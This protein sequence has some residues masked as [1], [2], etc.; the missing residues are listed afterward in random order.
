MS[1]DGSAAGAFIHK[2]G[3]NCA[4]DLFDLS[5]GGGQWP[6]HDS[7]SKIALLKGNTQSNRRWPWHAD[8]QDVLDILAENLIPCAHSCW[9]T[10]SKRNYALAIS[11]RICSTWR[12]NCSGPWNCSTIIQNRAAARF[13]YF[14]SGGSSHNH[15][16]NLPPSSRRYWVPT[17]GQW[18]AGWLMLLQLFAG[19]FLHRPGNTGKMGGEVLIEIIWSYR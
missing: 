13:F 5:G 10:T 3:R 17:R 11:G 2:C 9:K 4:C 16:P 8:G 19:S 12:I 7:R 6:V 1:I 14:V 15:R 18:P